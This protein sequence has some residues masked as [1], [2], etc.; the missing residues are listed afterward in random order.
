M[1]NGAESVRCSISQS[2]ASGRDSLLREPPPPCEQEQEQVRA[3][4]KP[5]SMCPSRPGKASDADRRSLP[6]RRHASDPYS[7]VRRTSV[8][9]FTLVELLVVI[10]II[11]V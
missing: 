8:C 3:E 7:R 9:G 2:H 11:A 10:G 1:R 5:V 6:M 4:G